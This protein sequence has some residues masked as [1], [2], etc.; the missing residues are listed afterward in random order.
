[1]LRI[2]RPIVGLRGISSHITRVPF[3]VSARSGA[4]CYSSAPASNGKKLGLL[5]VLGVLAVGTT[6]YSATTPVKPPRAYIEPVLSPAFKPGEVSVL[7]VLGGPGSGKGTQCAKLVAGYG[8]VHLS[9][10]DLLRAEQQRPG[11]KYGEL[12]AQYIKDGQIVPQEITIALL[13]QAMKEEFGKGKTKFLIDGFPRKMDQ[14]ITFEEQ[15]AQSSFTLFFDCP[16][17]VM[18]KRLLER[19]KT[20][21]RTD[22]NAETIS[23]RFKTFVET[24]YPVVEYFDKQGKVIRLSCDQPVETVYGQVTAA[25]KGKEII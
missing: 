18:L 20:S 6:L 23:K 21:G 11:S 25:L 14:A 9:A 22:D 15:V 7:F 10:G 5:A 1:M 2:A 3:A 4:R 24:S 17:A 8:F 19:G 12:I 16:E 13:E